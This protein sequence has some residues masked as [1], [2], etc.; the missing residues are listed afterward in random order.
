VLGRD[1]LLPPSVLIFNGKMMLKYQKQLSAYCER[2]E[3]A[4]GNILAHLSY[5][6]Q[7]QVKGK[8]SNTKGI[9]DVLKLVCVQQVLGIHFLVYN[10]LFSIVKGTDEMLSV[11]VSCIE[12]TPTHVKELYPVHVKSTI[13]THLYCHGKLDNILA[14]M[15]KLHALPS[16]EYHTCV[17][18]HATKAAFR[19]SRQGTCSV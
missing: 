11:V 6:R 14:C 18:A 8:D 7:I 1:K 9:G 10:D 3:K 15:A 4:A 19:S 5:L 17:G 13:G 12:D 2:E 16:K